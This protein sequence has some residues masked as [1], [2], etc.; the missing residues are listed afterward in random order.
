MK[1]QPF[2]EESKEIKEPQDILYMRYA[3]E[4]GLT[5]EK[6]GL[7]QLLDIDDYLQDGLNGGYLRMT[8]K[9]LLEEYERR[10]VRGQ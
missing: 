7:M 8:K 4:E 6:D 10:V 3:E 2:E 5:Q 9:E 1:I